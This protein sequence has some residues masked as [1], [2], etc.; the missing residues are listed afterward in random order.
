MYETKYDHYEYYSCYYC[1]DRLL[2]AQKPLWR[3]PFYG[4]SV[5]PKK[6]PKITMGNL[7]ESLF[8]A[9]P[10]KIRVWQSYN[11]GF[12]YKTNVKSTILVWCICI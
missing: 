8:F 5:G 9:Y 2:L 3:H 11:F 7:W 6:T 1:R 4:K 10:I 12:A